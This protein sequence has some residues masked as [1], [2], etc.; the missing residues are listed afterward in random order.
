MKIIFACVLPLAFI[1]AAHGQS[2]L[3]KGVILNAQDK[4]PIENV[5]IQVV[6]M[7]NTK[8]DNSGNFEFRTEENS[9]VLSISHIGFVDEEL[10]ITIPQKENLIVLLQPIVQQLEEVMVSTGYEDIPIHRATGS[11]EV[12]DNT[13]LNR[14]V[15]MDVLGRIENISSGVHFDRTTSSFNEVGR[16]PN[17]DIYIHGISTLRFGNAGRN[18]PLII[19]DHFPYEGDVNNINPNDIESITVLKDA[20]AAS[21]WGAKAGNGVIVIT[22]KRAKYEKPTQ[23]NFNSNIKI[24]ATPDLYQHRV[25]SPSDYIDIESFLFEQ[26]FYNNAENSR[27][28]PAL[29]P[30]VEILIKQR[31]GLF[32]EEEAQSQMNVLRE[33]DVRDDMLKYMYREA[34]QQQY[35]LNLSGGS[36][37]HHFI[38]GAGFDCSLPTQVGNEI[39]RLTLRLENSFKPIEPLELQTVVRWVSNRIRTTALNE[40]Y[41]DG[42]YKYPYV[43]LADEHGNPIPVPN[44]Y[45]MGFL[46]TAGAGQLLDWHYRPLD[47]IRNPPGSANEQELMLNLGMTYHLTPWLK[48]DVKYQHTR[49]MTNENVHNDLRSYYTRNHINRGTEIREGMPFYHFPYGGVLRRAASFSQGH[50]G[51]A[52]LSIN[53]G[54]NDA[55]QLNALAGTDINDLK[56]HSD[57]YTAYG[58]NDELLTY[59]TSID[60]TLRY[61]VYGNLASSGSIPYPIGDF[62]E[63]VQRFVSF[64]SNA[65]YSYKNRYT[66]S[67][68]ARRDASNLFGVSTN[69]KWTPLWSAGFSWSLSNES[70]YHLPY[71][72][73]LKMRLTYGYSGNIDNT[74]SAVPTLSYI[75][76][77]TSIFGIPLPAAQILNGPNPELRWEQVR[78]INFGIDFASHGN[79]ITGSVD[80]YQKRTKDLYDIAAL[81]PSTGVSQMTINAANTKSLGVDAR[82]T[83]QNLRGSFGWIS[84]WLFSYNNNWIVETH[85]NYTGPSSLVNIGALALYQ[86]QYA[87]PAL[88][89]KWGG[90][91]PHTGEAMGIIDGEPSKDYRALTGLNTKPEDLVF[92]GSARPLYF[93]AFRNTF[94]YHRISLSV[95]ISWKM[96]YYFRRGGLD[97][98]SVLNHGDAHLDYYRRWQKP[99]DELFTN[100]PAF[101]YPVNNQANN[102]YKYSEVLVEKGDHIRLQDVRVDYN[103]PF[104]TSRSTGNLN[105]FFYAANLGIIWRANNLNLDPDN[106]GAIPMPKSFSFG[107]SFN[108]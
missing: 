18:A 48:A 30:S 99:G 84:D 72:P 104:S 95:N 16:R 69:N 89:Y 19:L 6:D 13:L 12:I 71:L 32:T 70:F 43:L 8:S 52:Q 96:D 37:R 11:F 105:L 63:R 77:N 3:V 62:A 80:A 78:N 82:I 29:P 47:E 31:D 49:D 107:V 81:D 97:Y 21:I 33:N 38:L 23:V 56:F 98:G 17:H 94:R 58:Y 34:M 44:D 66:A 87:F 76:S 74:M 53:Y 61:P 42:G 100:I 108:Y 65:S 4:T 14:T 39:S 9:I 64:F 40:T 57:R 55:H 20:A 101:V 79:R 103:I 41:T 68:S 90:L 93:G 86:D 7:L 27:A 28:R 60:H 10:F 106:R 88:S 36:T 46:D 83:S 102:F 54:W 75:N 1:M 67:F 26:G 91:D 15:G 25:I 51:R 35:A 50:N 5:N 2:H 45:R 85:R 92:H 24:T 22:S 59:V 73:F